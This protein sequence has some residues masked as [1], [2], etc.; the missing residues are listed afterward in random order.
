MALYDDWGKGKIDENHPDLSW[1]EDHEVYPKT[2]VYRNQY[3]HFAQ[4][5]KR[6]GLNVRSYLSLGTGLGRHI[7]I[8]KESFPEVN[9]VVSVDS[10]IHPHKS[11][12]QLELNKHS[13]HKSTVKHA[14]R[15]LE[16][17]KSKFD[18]VIF[19]NIGHKHEIS[20]F[21][22]I[23]LLQKLLNPNSLLAF[24]GDTKFETT[25]L[26][27]TDNFIRIPN[28]TEEYGDTTTHNLWQF[29]RV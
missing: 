24:I 3:N 23:Q 27:G 25:L 18:L 8:C 21:E 13:H 4:V 10:K 11:L 7:V 12:S 9:S 19:E 15:A 14:L 16:N 29:K 26:L 5:A 6:L 20:S 17:Q 1:I 22:E 2:P 28:L